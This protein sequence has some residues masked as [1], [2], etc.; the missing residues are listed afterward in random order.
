VAKADPEDRYL[1]GKSLNGANGDPGVL[2]PARTG[3]NYDCRRPQLSDIVNRDPIVSG[4]LDFSPKHPEILEKIVS[5][6]I[7]VIDHE[8]H[9]IKLL[10]ALCEAWS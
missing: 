10:S 1:S 7:V 8:K 2:R 3:G 4:D 5:E 9:G 6:R